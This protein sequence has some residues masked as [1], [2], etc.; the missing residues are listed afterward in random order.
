LQGTG[1]VSW[2]HK[3]TDGWITG[4]LLHRRM[5]DEGVCPVFVQIC[6]GRNFVSNNRKAIRIIL[7]TGFNING[8]IP[9]TIKD[10]K[11]MPEAV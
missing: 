8:L 11:T 3:G 1:R 4:S 6:A 7:F 2:P 10:N 5:A 9:E